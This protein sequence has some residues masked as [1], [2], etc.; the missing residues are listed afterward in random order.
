MLPVLQQEH[1][2]RISEKFVENKTLAFEKA[3][4]R[5]VGPNK[6]SAIKICEWCKS[7]LR[8]DG[9]CYKQ[10]FYGIA[11]NQCIQMT[12]TVFVCTENCL[13]CWRPTR[14]ALPQ[15]NQKWDSPKEIMDDCIEEQK[16]ILQGFAGNPNTKAKKFY[17][18]MRP[19]HVAISLSGE[20]TLYP[21]IGGL[22]EDIRERKM[23]SF[24][25][26]NG[27]LPERIQ[28]LLDNDQ[29]P[30]QLYIT[31]AAPDK[32]TLKSTALNIFED[33]W[34]RLMISLSLLSQFNRSVVRLTLVR[35]LN[36]KNPEKYAEIIEKASPSFLEV[37]SFMAVGGAQYRLPYDSMLSHQEIMD[38]AAEIEKHSSYR[39]VENKGDS[40]VA[41]LTRDGRPNDYVPVD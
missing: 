29:H 6:H 23:T 24:L 5:F 25:V 17:N 7:S 40:R 15:K 30:T 35:D 26:T 34:E 37:K 39:I 2:P 32:E 27:T 21:Y 4:Y 8:E 31:L 11:S 41:L 19:K 10:K 28:G 13:F 36:F 12:P 1:L 22:I 18:A 14:Y 16:K 20:P 38:F 33:A 3:G 9:Y